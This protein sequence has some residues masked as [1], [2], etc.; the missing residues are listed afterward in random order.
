MKM[1]YA[2]KMK[3]VHSIVS[4]LEGRFGRSRAAQVRAKTL[5]QAGRPTTISFR[6]ASAVRATKIDEADA[7]VARASSSPNYAHAYAW[8]AS[9]GCQILARRQAR[10]IA[11][12]RH[13]R[14]EGSCRSTN[15]TPGAPGHGIR[16]AHSKKLALA[17]C[18]LKGHEQQPNDVYVIVDY[19]NCFPIWDLG[20]RD[21][22]FIALS[23]KSERNAASL[24]NPARRK[25]SRCIAKSRYRKASSSRPI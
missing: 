15:P 6:V 22:F 2:V 5:L 16:I 7:L 4:T 3:C 20:R 24:P 19:A 23:N 14:R 8:R 18:I 13:V 10:D 12:G 25:G 17:G 11:A 1:S 21:G 9:T